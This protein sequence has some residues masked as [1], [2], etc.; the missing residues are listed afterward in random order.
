MGGV[1]ARRFADE[2]A[3]MVVALDAQALTDWLRWEPAPEGASFLH[4]YAPLP[5]SAVVAVHRVAGAALV[6]EALPR[7]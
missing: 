1:A 2:P 4:V 5:L 6:D 7:G 3:L